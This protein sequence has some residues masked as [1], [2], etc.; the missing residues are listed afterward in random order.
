MPK[1]S[2]CYSWIYE[3]IDAAVLMSSNKMKI[4]KYLVA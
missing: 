2:S 3:R 1:R 4:A